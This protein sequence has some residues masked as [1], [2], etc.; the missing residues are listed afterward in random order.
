MDSNNHEAGYYEKLD[1]NRVLC[2]LCPHHCNIRPDHT[3][4]CGVRH[5][6]EGTLYAMSYGGITSVALDPI[7]KKPLARFN[8]GSMILSVGSYGCNFKCTFC[9]NHSIS[10]CKPETIYISP[11]DLVQK[12]LKLKP[13][14]NIGIAYTYNE[15]LISYEYVYDC[16][17]PARENGLKNVIVSNGYIEQEP[18]K[19]LLPFV[20]AMNIDLKSF[21]DDFYSK[22]CGGVPE[23]VR[24][25]IETSSKSC[26]VEVTTLIIPGLNDSENEMDSL[27]SWLASVN[28]EI[29]LH[30]SRFF[31]TY[32]MQDRP[33]TP[34]ETIRSLVRIAKQRLKYVYTGNI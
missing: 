11:E 18:L 34:V 7:E 25:T 15:P 3:G 6:R 30:L 14:G 1:G 31:P 33:P 29:P 28:P 24:N 13:N 16:C 21:G 20:D 12:A 9:Q 27:V 32:K 23:H 10:M 26:H 19:E 2:R 17:V 5:N 8:P 4:I 22:I